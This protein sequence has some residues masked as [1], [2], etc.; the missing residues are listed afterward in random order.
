[1][2]DYEPAGRVTSSDHLAVGEINCAYTYHDSV[3]PREVFG[4]YLLIAYPVLEA[5]DGDVL[6]HGAKITECFIRILAFHAEQY[7]II[8]LKA[9][10]VR[11]GKCWQPQGM[12]ANR[13]NQSQTVFPNSIHV[14][15][16]SYQNYLVTHTC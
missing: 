1:M 3:D 5:E 8:W 11:A 10:L 7:H 9:D 13:G 12:G 15:G 2:T 6:G 14:T 16:P 4:S